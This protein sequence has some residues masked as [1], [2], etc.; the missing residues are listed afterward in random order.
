[1][2]WSDKLMKFLE[3]RRYLDA[4]NVKSA[5]TTAY[6]HNHALFQ[7]K[8]SWS[9]V[10]N[11]PL[12]TKFLRER[13][14]KQIASGQPVVLLDGLKRKIYKYPVE[15]GEGRRLFEL[16]AVLSNV[17][18]ESASRIVFP[19]CADMLDTSACF[20]V[21]NMYQPPLSKERAQK[22]I[23]WFVEEVVAAVKEL[24]ALDIAHLDIRLENICIDYNSS[25][26]ML[27]DLDRSRKAS[28][29]DHTV[30]DLYGRHE[31]YKFESSEWTLSHLDWKQVG[32]MIEAIIESPHEANIESPHEA[33]IEP[34]QRHEFIQELI[35][36]GTL[37][38]CTISYRL[39]TVIS[40]CTCIVFTVVI[41]ATELTTHI[42]FL[43]G[44]Y[45][46]AMHKKW[47]HSF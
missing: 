27:I 20:V 36:R 18:R 34:P 1:M 21:L 35:K 28:V 22:Y 40:D 14:L 41:S 13:N 43:S 11:Y 23:V 46:P 47:N 4:R 17:V 29:C 39:L 19:L 26:V 33:N 12:S 6:E 24:H 5:L 31:M 32:L 42:P 9:M 7:A 16:L 8:K 10:L 30:Y 44:A 38:E 37:M 25:K 45:V 3:Q 15:P 2:E